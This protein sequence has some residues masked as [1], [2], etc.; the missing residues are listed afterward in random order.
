MEF[1]GFLQFLK[2]ESPG[3]IDNQQCRFSADSM[4]LKNRGRIKFCNVRLG[5][6]RH[7]YL[8]VPIEYCDEVFGRV[9]GL[10]EIGSIEF[11]RKKVTDSRDRNP[12]EQRCLDLIGKHNQEDALLY[13]YSLN[14]MHGLE[15]GR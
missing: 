2:K 14:T 5:I 13:E 3:I 15:L 10:L 8:I 7:P 6:E 4:G 1:Y 11:K 12:I 9:S